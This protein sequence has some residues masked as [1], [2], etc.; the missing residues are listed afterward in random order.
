MSGPKE[1]GPSVFMEA[2]EYITKM[3]AARASDEL[4]RLGAQQRELMEKLR[5]DGGGYNTR[6]KK[7][8]LSALEDLMVR[9]LDA[10]ER[11]LSPSSGVANLRSL[12]RRQNTQTS[13]TLKILQ[14][15]GR[16]MHIKD[17]VDQ[18]RIWHGVKCT[19][20][21]LSSALLKR[22][23]AGDPID[24]SAPNTF[25][26]TGDDASPAGSDNNQE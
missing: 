5:N 14:D 10:V 15:A 3:N 22:I 9:Q 12:S 23:N 26:Y 18:L 1:S 20:E 16:P 13:L 19:P 25:E 6:T 11:L 17:I 4:E 24:R 2:E 8:A 7:L 21:T